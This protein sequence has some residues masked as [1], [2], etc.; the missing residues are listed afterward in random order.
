VKFYTDGHRVSP[1][2]F[3]LVHTTQW[4]HCT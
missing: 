2:K 3:A 4:M 1:I